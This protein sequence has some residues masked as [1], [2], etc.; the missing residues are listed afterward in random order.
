MTDSDQTPGPLRST[1]RAA[2]VEAAFI[3]QVIAAREADALAHREAICDLV[4]EDP[5]FAD[6]AGLVWSV[7]GDLPTRANDEPEALRE[8]L[9]KLYV[10][11]EER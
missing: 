5:T 2:R 9:V 7:V 10:A 11:G 4:A 8:R 6:I 1:G 3:R